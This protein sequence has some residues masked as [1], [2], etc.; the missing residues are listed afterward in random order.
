MQ[1]DAFYQCNCSG[2]EAILRKRRKK[3]TQV[4]VFCEES[5]AAAAPSFLLRTSL[6][7]PYQ[8]R[9]TLSHPWDNTLITGS[10]S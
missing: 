9:M 2:Q 4:G 3:K 7:P 10:Q 1:N 6:K 5:E 8:G